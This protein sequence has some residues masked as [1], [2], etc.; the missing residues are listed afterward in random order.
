[1]VS[2]SEI[3]AHFSTIRV[4]E[5]LSRPSR[6]DE[7]GNYDSDAELTDGIALLGDGYN[8]YAFIFEEEIDGELTPFVLK[9]SEDS[10]DNSEKIIRTCIKLFSG[11]KDDDVSPH[12]PVVYKYEESD[13]FI[14]TFYDMFH[15][16]D[17][18]LSE[19]ANEFDCDSD[20]AH[21]HIVQFCNEGTLLDLVSDTELTSTEVKVMLF[22]IFFT[23]AVI[24]ERYPNFR[25]SDLHAD[26]ILIDGYASRTNGCNLYAFGGVDHYLPD[27]GI[28]TKLWDYE[29]AT[30]GD[31][32]MITNT[33]IHRGLEMGIS[34]NY[35]SA[36]FDVHP[37]LNNIISS[38]ADDVPADIVEWA[39]SI[40]PDARF[41]G[42]D[43]D[44]GRKRMCDVGPDDD[45]SA[46]Y[47]FAD[48]MT[49][50]WA[51]L[52]ILR[53]V[54][55]NT[56]SEILNEVAYRM[57]IDIPRVTKKKYKFVKHLSPIF[58]ISEAERDT[59]LDNPRYME[60][61]KESALMTRFLAEVKKAGGADPKPLI[62][63]LEEGL[64]PLNW[65][66]NSFLPG[67][68]P[69]EK[70]PAEIIKDPFFD[71]FRITR[72]EA[73]AKYGEINNEYNRKK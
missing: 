22:E 15:D 25:H 61:V 21:L 42:E 46:I 26:N 1:M 30:F 49:K 9:F 10:D 56:D 51:R 33:C 67:E 13:T 55:H 44:E 4:D 29:F 65:D 32:D 17:N 58:C 63:K 59:L 53:Y 6:K 41:Q 34:N 40:V 69:F 52:K 7:D 20:V 8:G 54:C 62:D 71:E 60:E 39:E 24:T 64:G 47:M 38:F 36:F 23:L 57:D 18:V 43:F 12:F 37:I 70:T 3:E 50:R 48:R 5:L 31:P 45:L 2:H 14:D 66:T 68:L 11:L 27:T 19:I 72:E 73:V 28:M 16:A 35:N